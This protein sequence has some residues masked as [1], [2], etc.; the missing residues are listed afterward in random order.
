MALR[1]IRGNELVAGA[2]GLL[3]LASLFMPWFD[4]RSA[5]GSLAV[6]DILLCLVAAVA[7]WLLL[8]AAAR[9]K[10]D[11]PIVVSALTALAGAIGLLIVLYRLL[12]PVGTAGRDYGLLV[13]LAA[14]LLVVAGGWRAMIPER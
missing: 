8:A 5:W 10:T 4:G 11:V 6:A 2:G 9:E 13:A 3:L 1:R 7:V 14:S 12:D